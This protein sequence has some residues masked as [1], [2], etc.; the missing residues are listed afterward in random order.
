LDGNHTCIHAE[1]H[2]VSAN[3]KI[4]KTKP[5]GIRN[6]IKTELRKTIQYMPA[7]CV[8]NDLSFFSFGNII[9]VISLCSVGEDVCRVPKRFNLS[10]HSLEATLQ[11]GNEDN[12]EDDDRSA[13]Q[14]QQGSI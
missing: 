10:L 11:N 14:S 12:A 8:D 1:I 4:N 3:P 6:L 7:I 2:T 9:L 13:A 5:I